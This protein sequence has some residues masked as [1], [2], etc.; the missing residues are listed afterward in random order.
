MSPKHFYR[1]RICKLVDITLHVSGNQY[2]GIRSNI[3]HLTKVRIYV[4][5][6]YRAQDVDNTVRSI[7]VGPVI[8]CV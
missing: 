4:I 6:Q 1:S 5:T 7:R 2:N 3:G 8:C